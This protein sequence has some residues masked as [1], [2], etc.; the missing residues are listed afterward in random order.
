MVTQ[1]LGTHYLSRHALL[2][3]ATHKNLDQAALQ[4]GKSW[5]EL[6]W[7]AAQA[8]ANEVMQ[9]WP[10]GSV[11]VLCGRGLNGAD[12]FLC[13]ELLRQQGRTVDI[14][15]LYAETELSPQTSWAKQQWHGRL[16]ST[17]QLA[18]S[19]YTVVVDAMVGAGL[20]RPLDAK[21]ATLLEQ[22][23]HA[24]L[25]VCAIDL[26]S[27]MDGDSG[28]YVGPQ[29]RASCTVTFERYKPAHVLQPGASY[30]GDIVLASLAVPSQAYRTL[31]ISSW[32]NDPQ[33]WC[34][35][36]PWPTVDSHKFTRGHAVILGGESLTGAS[37]LAARAA[38][39]AGAGLVSLYVPP[40][41]WAPCA[42]ALES[43][44]VGKLADIIPDDPRISAY[45][46]GPGAGVNA[47]TYTRVM[48][49][50]CSDK[51]VVLDADALTVFQED[52][53]VLWEAMCPECVITPHEGE[54]ARLF[55]DLQGPNKLAR[56]KAAA[57]RSGAVVVL[58]GSDTV[59]AAPDG[60]C[61]VNVVASPFLATGG[62]GDVL[63]GVI[64]GLLAQGMPVFEAAAAAVWLHGK[65]G[66]NHGPGLIPEDIIH[67]L[68]RVL[69]E[70]YVNNDGCK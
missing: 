69:N 5:A 35:V 1:H 19:H 66:L 49:L 45:L 70:L 52:P 34:D 25:P 28:Q 46:Y 56:A 14:C 22:L 55:K 3:P 18:L 43:I 48:Q 62:S 7:S 53:S 4:A 33:L 57:Q 36:L 6:L 12:G 30:C 64:T 10:Q 51:P 37:R 59:I 47:Q 9:R 38:Q 54:F 61:I 41:V 50:L 26:P 16:V 40:S 13:G 68:P 67:A 60:R 63:A 31:P 24:N 11:L 58:K 21:L 29:L 44:M 20:N 17:A 65:I 42:A 23:M 15:S 2:D 39:R 32:R 27:G 8:V